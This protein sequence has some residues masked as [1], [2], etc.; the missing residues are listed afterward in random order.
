MRQEQGWPDGGR[1]ARERRNAARQ[2]EGLFRILARR[3]RR[4]ERRGGQ[5]RRGRVVDRRHGLPGPSDRL[6]AVGRSRRRPALLTRVVSGVA[7]ALDDGAPHH[8]AEIRRALGRSRGEQHHQGRH[9]ELQAC[10]EPLHTDLGVIACSRR[11][12]FALESR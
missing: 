2:A 5:V 6:A 12:R 3:Q 4:D 1:R 7:T 9:Q 8:L 11:G 10:A